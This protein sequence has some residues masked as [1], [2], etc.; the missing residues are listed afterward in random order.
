VDEARVR[1]VLAAAGGTASQR[2]AQL[3]QS[4]QCGTSCGSCLPA[5]RGLVDAVRPAP[6]MSVS[7]ST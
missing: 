2:L 4:L 6:P 5:L 7:A 1:V 3:Q